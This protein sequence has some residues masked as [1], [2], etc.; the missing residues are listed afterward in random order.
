[1]QIDLKPDLSL[2]AIMVIFILNYLVVRRFFLQPINDVLESREE[3]TKS[4]EKL[5]EDALARFNDATAQMEAQL[6]TAKREAAQ[7]REKFRGEAAAHRQQVVAKTSDEA[8]QVVAQADE[9]LGRDVAQ[10]RETIVRDS[11]S[12]ARLAAERLLGRAV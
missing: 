10:A 5:Y 7:V 3:E 11:E 6:H 9:K 8:R 1:M 2:L 12:L 4:A